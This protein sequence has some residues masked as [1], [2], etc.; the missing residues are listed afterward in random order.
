M[1]MN[2]HVI[3]NKNGSLSFHLSTSLTQKIEKE[4]KSYGWRSSEDYLCHV[5]TNAVQSLAIASEMEDETMELHYDVTSDKWLV[6]ADG[7]LMREFQSA[8]EVSDWFH[9][10]YLKDHKGV[11]YGNAS[12]TAI[13][14]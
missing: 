8:Y 14:D 9:K 10:E 2:T 3:R 12:E 4:A 6:E 1:S 13:A 7:I 5:C 11:C